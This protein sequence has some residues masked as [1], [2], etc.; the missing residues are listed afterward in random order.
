MHYS[1]ATSSK[2]PRCTSGTAAIGTS[3]SD[4]AAIGIGGLGGG[5]NVFV[6]ENKGTGVSNNTVAKKN[7]KLLLFFMVF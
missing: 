6:A 7:F 4:G 2:S 3:G 1:I 5:N